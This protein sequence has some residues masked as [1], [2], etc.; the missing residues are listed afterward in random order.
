[1]TTDFTLITPASPKGHLIFTLGIL[2]L[3]ETVCTAAIL[4]FPIFHI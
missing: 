4:F 2:Y 3:T 1:M